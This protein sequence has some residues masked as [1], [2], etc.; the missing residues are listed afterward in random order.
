MRVCAQLRASREH[1]DHSLGHKIHEA[2]RW[3]AATAL[4]LD[5]ELVSDDTAF[6]SVPGLRVNTVGAEQHCVRRWRAMA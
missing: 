5:I 4:R 1:D 6:R 2:D 3:I